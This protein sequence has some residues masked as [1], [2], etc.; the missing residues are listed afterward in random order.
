MNI[1]T[2]IGVCVHVSRN[3]CIYR[4]RESLYREQFLVLKGE[5]GSE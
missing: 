5:W 2:V 1:G 3:I 4:Y